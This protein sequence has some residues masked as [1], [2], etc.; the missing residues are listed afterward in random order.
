MA[1][2]TVKSTQITNR[3][4]TPRVAINGRVQGGSIRHARGV[5]TVTSGNDIASKYIACSVPSNAV[6]VSLRLSSPDLGTTTVAD[7]GLYKTTADGSAVVDADLFGSAV[8]L[9]D[10]AISKSEVLFESTTIT[11]ANSE[12]ALW[13]HLGLTSDPNLFY[14]IVLTLTAAADGTGSVLVEAD[15]TI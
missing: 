9:K 4:A 7:V 11:L 10:G 14:D 3:D 5:C 2:V 1:V 8:S 15:Y 13:E 6:M 12:K